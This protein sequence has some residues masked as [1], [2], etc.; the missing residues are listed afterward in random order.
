MVSVP[1]HP[2]ASAGRGPAHRRLTDRGPRRLGL[3]RRGLTSL[4]PAHRRLTRRGRW[5][6][7]GGVVVGL[8]A[9]ALNERDLLFVAAVGVL[10]PTLAFVFA[11]A[12]RARIEAQFLV[13]PRHVQA[14]DSGAVRLRVRNAGSGRSPSLDLSI[15]AAPGL[16][17]DVRHPV[18]PLPA[19]G[20]AEVVIPF[21]AARRGRHHVAPPTLRL[22]DPLSLWELRQELAATVEVL[23]TPAVVPL[24]GMPHGASRRGSGSSAEAAWAAS[25]EPDAGVRS[26]RNGDDP[27]TIHWRASA[28]L[29]D[30]L[31]VRAPEASGLVAAAVLLDH[32]VRRH[33][34]V[35]AAREGDGGIE[36]A[37]T[38]TASIGCHLVNHDVEL[39]LT[40]HTGTVLA[41]GHEGHDELLA[42]LISAGTGAAGGYEEDFHAVVPGRPDVVIAVLGG[43][44]PAEAMDVARARSRG[45]TGLAFLVGADASSTRG[46][47]AAGLLLAAGWRVVDVEHARRGPDAAHLAEVWRAACAAR[48]AHGWA[49]PG[50]R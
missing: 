6:G 26:Y 24:W 20:G 7:V 10:L 29:E 34:G 22:R 45:S 25:G 36:T 40:D 9:V 32:R 27:R 17:W 44:T 42:S 21:V 50:P 46:D 49:G 11:G 12:R 41:S 15:P 16:T 39:T 18:P 14:G 31:V 35:A 8:L 13:T 2:P 47:E 5:L 4:A 1:D 48:T 19:G 30:D 3:R 23:V 37:V 38:L 28:R 33:V 43:L